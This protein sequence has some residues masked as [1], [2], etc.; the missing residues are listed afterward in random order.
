MTVHTVS[1]KELIRLDTIMQLH[2]KTLSRVQAA[3]LLGISVRQVQRL[4]TRYRY[5]GVVG[6]KSA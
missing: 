2:E 3:E 5:E 6:P 4:S 1:D